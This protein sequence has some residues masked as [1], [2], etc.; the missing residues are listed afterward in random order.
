MHRRAAEGNFAYRTPTTPTTGGTTGGGTTSG[1]GGGAAPAAA[2]TVVI[3]PVAVP[4]A[5]PTVA[6]ADAAEEAPEGE[7]LTTLED[8]VTPLAGPKDTTNTVSLEGFPVPLAGPVA[9]ME[10]RCPGGGC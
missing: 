9:Q 5:V 6:D 7:G 8:E 1:T 4:L 10:Q 2:P 3:P